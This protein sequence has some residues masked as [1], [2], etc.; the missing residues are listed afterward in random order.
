MSTRPQRKEDEEEVSWVNFW[1]QLR[2]DA[3]RTFLIVKSAFGEFVRKYPQEASYV[4]VEDMEAILAEI[5]EQLESAPLIDPIV[6]R[7]VKRRILW[8][9]VVITILVLWSIIFFSK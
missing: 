2:T 8:V 7:Q 4:T 1:E 6:L 3:P 5:K 9:V